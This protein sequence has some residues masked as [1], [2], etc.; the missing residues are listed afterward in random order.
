MGIKEL[1][2]LLTLGL[3]G[4][5]AQPIKVKTETVEVI[6]PILFCPAVDLNQA[7][8]PEFLPIDTIAIDTS[9]GEVAILYKATVKV[10]VDYTGRLE[11][12]LKEYGTFNKSY[13]ELIEELNLEKNE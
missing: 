13:E 11:L 3:I 10:L 7:T 9:D 5:S 4:C 6:K 8:R 12:L 2:L 1:T